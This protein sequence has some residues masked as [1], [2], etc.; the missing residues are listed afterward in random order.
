MSFAPPAFFPAKG[1]AVRS[2]IDAIA[3]GKGNL[4]KHPE[5]FILHELGTFDDQDGT[6]TNVDR[7]TILATGSD[8]LARPG[9]LTIAKEA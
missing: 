3:D 9:A 8:Y 5:D 2:F 7:P 4:G 1:A 6:F